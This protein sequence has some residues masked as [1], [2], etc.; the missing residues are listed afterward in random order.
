M[1]EQLR[2]ALLANETDVDG[3]LNRLGN[4]EDLYIS[5]LLAF[6]HDETLWNLQ[7]AIASKNWDDAFTAAHALKGLAGN[8]GFTPLFHSI[9]ELVITIRNGKMDEISSSFSKAKDCY[10]DIVKII[11]ADCM[12]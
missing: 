1:N 6:L 8:L 5:L 7:Q 11:N 9:G 4:D 3:A 2:D 12:K 10:E